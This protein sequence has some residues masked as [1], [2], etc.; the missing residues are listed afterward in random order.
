MLQ[1]EFYGGR[2]PLRC[3]RNEGGQKPCEIRPYT[4]IDFKALR[5]LVEPWLQ[6]NDYGHGNRE[7]ITLGKSRREFR[8][9][10]WGFWPPSGRYYSATV[11][12]P[13]VEPNDV[14]D[15]KCLFPQ[16]NGR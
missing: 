9:I 14:D 11:P 4:R 7:P 1:G 12:D 13:P 2:L 8:P 10:V 3:H 16:Q 6:S 15:S 5:K